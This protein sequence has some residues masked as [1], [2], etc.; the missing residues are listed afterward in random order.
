MFYA[1]DPQKLCK[2]G[3]MILIKRLPN[4][5]K[6]VLTHEV[7]EVVYPLGD[8]VDPVTGEKCVN[9]MPR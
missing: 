5:I 6:R 9:L 1:Y 3:D 2:T 4:V 7:L 8:V